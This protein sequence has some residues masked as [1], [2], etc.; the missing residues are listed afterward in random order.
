MATAS[1]LLNGQSN[2]SE[3]LSSVRAGRL[4]TS[5]A[6]ILIGSFGFWALLYRKEGLLFLRWIYENPVSVL[7]S[8]GL[9]HQGS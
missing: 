7:P 8:L 4:A 9:S 1:L 2:G 5:R 3:E 6:L